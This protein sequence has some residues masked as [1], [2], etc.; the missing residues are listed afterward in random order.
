M[1]AAK[2]YQRAHVVEYARTWAL[3]RNPLFTRFDTFGG[4]CTNFV[5]QCIFAGS[6]V[7]N[8]TPTFGWYYRAAGDYAPAWTGVPFLY[9]FLTENMDVGPF[10]EE[11]PVESAEPGDVIQ[12]GRSDGTFY[13][14]LIV[15]GM[16]DGVPLICAHDNDALDRSLSTYTYDRARAIHILGVRILIAASDCCYEGMLTGTSIFPSPASAAA[17]SCLPQEMRTEDT[18]NAAGSSDQPDSMPEAPMAE[19]RL[20]TEREPRPADILPEDFVFPQSDTGTQ[21]DLP[22]E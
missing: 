12:L 19:E 15:V 4:D 18:P 9:N 10:G 17:L 21:S 2:P 13:H 3:S 7:M 16:R 22:A 20:E 1:I 5:S 6:C 14:T 11:I 8:E